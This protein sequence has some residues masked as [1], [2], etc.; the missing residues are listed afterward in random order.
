MGP[1]ANSTSQGR[2]VAVQNLTT[3]A[4]E[5]TAMPRLA[6][7]GPSEEKPWEQQRRRKSLNR[8]PLDRGEPLSVNP[9]LEEQLE[10]PL[11]VN[12]AVPVA[13]LGASFLWDRVQTRSPRALTPPQKHLANPE[14]PFLGTSGDP[15][16]ISVFA[17]LGQTVRLEHLILTRGWISTLGDRFVSCGQTAKAPSG[18]FSGSSTSDGGTLRNSQ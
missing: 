6:S 7:Q 12:P 8:T 9:G 3:L 13:V 4:P 5:W 2:D 10:E 1:D 11:S 18:L 16:V 17:V 15:T 14:E